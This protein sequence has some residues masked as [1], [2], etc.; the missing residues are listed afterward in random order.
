MLRWLVDIKMALA[1]LRAT[2][3]RTMLTVLG[4]VIG[5]ASVT[6]VMTLGEGAKNAVRGQISALGDNLLTIRPGK[7]SRDGAGNIISYN[8]L[9]SASQ[10]IALLLPPPTAVSRR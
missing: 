4:I 6:A 5:V 9:A 10:R 1:N 2:R 8:Y 7:A 3:V